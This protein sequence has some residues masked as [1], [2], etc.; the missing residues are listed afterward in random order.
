MKRCMAHIL[1]APEEQITTLDKL[2]VGVL[3][4][5]LSTGDIVM[6]FHGGFVGIL[7]ENRHPG[8]SGDSFSGRISA[9]EVRIL[10]KGSTLCITQQ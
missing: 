6:M 8:M 9:L 10:P 7:R 1:D 4:Q 5:V 3:A 2:P